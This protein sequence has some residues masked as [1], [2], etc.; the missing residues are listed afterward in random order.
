MKHLPGKNNP[1]LSSPLDASCPASARGFFVT[2]GSEQ[3]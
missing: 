1:G 2:R 3:G